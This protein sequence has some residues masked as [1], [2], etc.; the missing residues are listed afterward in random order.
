MSETALTTVRRTEALGLASGLLAAFAAG[1]VCGDAAHGA[2]LASAAL[3]AGDVSGA[4]AL[5]EASLAVLRRLEARGRDGTP[6]RGEQAAAVALAVGLRVLLGE[7]IDSTL[8]RDGNSGDDNLPS[9]DDN[10][11]DAVGCGATSEATSEAASKPTSVAAGKVSGEAAGL[12]SAPA[13]SPNGSIAQSNGAIAQSNGSVAQSNGSVAQSNGSVAQ[14]NGS[15]AQS[16]GADLALR[17]SLGL[18]QCHWE[19]CDAWEAALSAQSALELQPATA[20]LGSMLGELETLLGQAAASLGLLALADEVLRGAL[21]RAPPPARATAAHTKVLRRLN[22][23]SAGGDVARRALDTELG[24]LTTA[25]GEAEAG[26]WR[27]SVAAEMRS[28]AG[29]GRLASSGFLTPKDVGI[30]HD[31]EIGDATRRALHTALTYQVRA[32]TSH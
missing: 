3:A 16:A 4:A 24:V 1:L 26:K 2:S 15:V 19:R 12:A 18:A 22:L 30:E 21:R 6:P 8:L 14:S 10:L 11:L 5:F 20:A 9:R 23:M 29:R 31:L 27:R 32:V 25:L 28:S 7:T 17:L 13:S